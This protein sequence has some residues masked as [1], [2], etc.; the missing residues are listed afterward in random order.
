MCW[1]LLAQG[2]I[3]V[4]RSGGLFSTCMDLAGSV[5]LGSEGKNDARVVNQEFIGVGCL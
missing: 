2:V 5:S 3:M 1:P 4:R